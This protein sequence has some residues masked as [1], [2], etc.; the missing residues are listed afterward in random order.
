MPVVSL[1]KKF[2]APL[3]P[4]IV[5]AR[6]AKHRANFGAFTRLQQDHQD[7]ANA[8]QNVNYCNHDDHGFMNF[9]LNS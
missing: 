4:K 2:P 1:L 3:L 6:A 8:N 7:Q 5:A 9:S